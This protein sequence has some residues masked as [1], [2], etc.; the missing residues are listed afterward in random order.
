MFIKATT[1][2]HRAEVVFN[3]KVRATTNLSLNIHKI[4][5]VN[6]F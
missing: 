1:S 2:F 4:S 6:Y 5:R 3:S